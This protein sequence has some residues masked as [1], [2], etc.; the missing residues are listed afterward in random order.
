MKSMCLGQ[1]GVCDRAIAYNA[2]N[3]SHMTKNFHALAH[4]S[5]NTSR[6]QHHT[7]PHSTHSH[8]YPPTH[9]PDRAI[10]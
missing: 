1:R 6:P 7:N 10:T 2:T 4:E 8:I 3:I 5:H 9:R